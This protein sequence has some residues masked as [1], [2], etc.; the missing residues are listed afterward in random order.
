MNVF[1]VITQLGFCSVYF[2]FLGE[3]LHQVKYVHT[4][5]VCYVHHC[6]SLPRPS[7]FPPPWPFQIM[8]VVYCIDLDHRIWSA[9][10]IPIITIF[11]WIRNLDNLAPLSLVANVGIFFGIFVI[12]CDE[13]YKLSTHG[14]DQAVITKD[15]SQ[16]NASTSF[17]KTCL[18]FGNAIYTFEG[19]G[20]V[21]VHLVGCQ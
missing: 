11:S 4:S 17:L 3:T 7:S 10:L 19:I 21:S 14:E 8:N 18:F 9:I 6:Y 15:S 2:V 5:L 20:V 12:T 13:L 16:L 1:L